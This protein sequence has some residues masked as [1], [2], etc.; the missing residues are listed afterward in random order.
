[1]DQLWNLLIQLFFYPEFKI[2]PCENYLD[3][4]Q[5]TRPIQKQPDQLVKSHDDEIKK[6]IDE[7][8]RKKNSLSMKSISYISYPQY[9][10]TFKLKKKW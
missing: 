9:V 5:L 2:K 7:I 4:T 3:V 8:G 10:S 1:M 6:K